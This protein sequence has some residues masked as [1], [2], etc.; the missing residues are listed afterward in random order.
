MR[1][2]KV[3]ANSYGEA[4]TRVRAELGERALVL[5]T[6]SIKF[7]KDHD[8]GQC[9]TMVEITAALDNETQHES[10][11]MAEKP[12]SPQAWLPSNN[13]EEMRELRSMITSLLTQTEKAKSLGLNGSQFPVYEKLIGRGV[14]DRVVARVFEQLNVREQRK[15][16][17]PFVGESDLA[18][19]MKGA[20]KCEG[21]I[22]LDST[23]GPK[24]V[25]LVGPT[26][27]GKTTTTAKLAARF[28]L[29]Q[30]KKVA[31]VS[32]DTYRMGAYEQL[33]SY[34]ELMQ[35][36]VSLAADRKEFTRI[37][38]DHRDKDLVLVDTMG[39]SHRDPN[40]SRQLKHVL[41]AVPGIETHLVQSATSQEAVVLECFKQ[42]APLGVDRV[43]FTKLDEAVHFG[44]LFNCSVRH[45]IPFSYF[46]AGQ[47]VPEDIEVA[48]QDKVIRLIFN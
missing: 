40:Y 13:G 33:E 22:R 36:P 43:L 29:Q 41:A 28:A 38:Q 48:A 27:A 31:M 7:N 4:L 18:E 20:V 2:K 10:V 34:G 5:S 3:I 26:G 11:A 21:P 16:G 6:R 46:T 24:V 32:L 1:I 9:S 14:D 39:K 45:R 42:F 25:A 37:M 19:V 23:V 15:E 35:V 30:G 17:D 47:R 8:A 12:G 44:L